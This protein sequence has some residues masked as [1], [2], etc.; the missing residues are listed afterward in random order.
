MS[1]G[2]ISQLAHMTGFWVLNSATVSVFSEASKKPAAFR[3]RP[4]GY[5]ATS[6]SFV[7]YSATV[8]LRPIVL[9]L[10]EP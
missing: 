3:L 1:C 4:L 8:R 2:I 10:A 5:G 6:R 9:R 7:L